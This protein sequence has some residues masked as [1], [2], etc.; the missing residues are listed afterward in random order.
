MLLLYNLCLNLD[1]LGPVI[2]LHVS[3]GI[4]DEQQLEAPGASRA[5]SV[6][7]LWQQAGRAGRREQ[8]SVS[9]YVGFD[10]PLDQ[11][12]MHQPANLFARPIETAQVLEIPS[13]YNGACFLRG[14]SGQSRQTYPSHSTRQKMKDCAV[15][16]SWANHASANCCS[17][18]D[19]C[20]GALLINPKYLLR[21]ADRP[22]K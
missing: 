19:H 17:C 21:H 8:A 6:A 22:G 10:G 1:H 15:V 7:S 12:F 20:L 4:L 11:F 3:A 14:Q 13:L 9:I 16:I 2:V 18:S 5:G